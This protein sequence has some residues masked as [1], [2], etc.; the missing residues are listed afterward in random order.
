MQHYWDDQKDLDRGLDASMP[1]TRRCFDHPFDTSKDRPSL[2]VDDARYVSVVYEKR[3]RCLLAPKYFIWGDYRDC[4]RLE[5]DYGVTLTNDELHLTAGRSRYIFLRWLRALGDVDLLPAARGPRLAWPRVRR[6]ASDTSR[7]HIVKR[8]RLMMNRAESAA[9]HGETDALASLLDLA[10]LPSDVHRLIIRFVDW[11]ALN[12][13]RGWIAKLKAAYD[14]VEASMYDAAYPVV[15][16]RILDILRPKATPSM[17]MSVVVR[18]YLPFI[19]NSR[20][21]AA[22]WLYRAVMRWKQALA[23]IV[24]G[25]VPLMP[26]VNPTSPFSSFNIHAALHFPTVPNDHNYRGYY[27]LVCKKIARYQRATA[28]FAYRTTPIFKVTCTI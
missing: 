28:R 13:E 5:R 11:R 24:C 18:R 14:E 1:K 6:P 8:P 22:R 2:L 4:L 16:F 10:V 25:P 9:P 23:S 21:D 19:V 17:P 7:A 26:W 3:L 27:A 12:L 15:E 20:R